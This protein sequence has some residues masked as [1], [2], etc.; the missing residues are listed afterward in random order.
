MRARTTPF[1]PLV[2]A[3]AVGAG[4]RA[5]T[6]EGDG[7]VV[8]VRTCVRIGDGGYAYTSAEWRQEPRRHVTG[9]PP[10]RSPCRRG[11]A[12]AALRRATQRRRRRPRPEQGWREPRQRL[13]SSVLAARSRVLV[14]ALHIA[15]RS[16]DVATSRRSTTVGVESSVADRATST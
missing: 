13:Q 1:F 14:Y 9:A 6:Y 2:L 7:V 4:R 12:P 10:L 8:D 5:H 16:V 3:T 15:R 11:F